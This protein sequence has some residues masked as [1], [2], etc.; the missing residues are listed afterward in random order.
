MIKICDS[1][2]HSRFSFDGTELPEE[3]IVKAVRN[4]MKGL[5]FTDHM[6]PD[7]GENGTEW[8]FDP[9]S[10][11]DTLLPLAGKYSGD[12][13]LSI[14]MEFGMQPHLGP[15][16]QKLIRNYPFEYVIGSQ[17]L[18]YGEDPYEQEIFRKHPAADVVREY[19]DELFE[20]LKALP[21]ISTLGHIEYIFRYLPE[22][23]KVSLAPYEDQIRNILRYLIDHG[24]ALEYNTGSLEYLNGLRAE[25]FRIYKRM[26]GKNVTIGSDAH[27]ANR[28]GDGFAS[29]A[30]KLSQYGFDHYSF[31]TKTGICT[32]NI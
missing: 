6:D 26:G 19:Y 13:E 20:G 10:Y 3:M 21:G 18:V 11:F 15:C 30:V 28:L 23:E 2:T 14:G 12:I 22:N 5:C 29:A 1:H 9:E 16:F 24:I 25:I 27:T 31:F 7:F 4:G 32:L 8:T 17:H